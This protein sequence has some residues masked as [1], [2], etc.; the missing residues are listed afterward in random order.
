LFSLA[1]LL[2]TT[3]S[4]FASFELLLLPTTTGR[5]QRID[6]ETG[7]ALGSY[8]GGSGP[9]TFAATSSEP[10]VS[11]TGDNSGRSYMQDYSTGSLLP[12]SAYS[13]VTAFADYSARSSVVFLTGN[14]LRIAKRADLSLDL[15]VTGGL[16]PG[17]SWRSGTVVGD[18]YY[19][20]GVSSTNT[21][22]WQVINLLN[23]GSLGAG[24]YGTTVSTV[25][26]LVG[27]FSGST[28]YWTQN[29]SGTI[30]VMRASLLA[31]SFGTS[32]EQTTLSS[33]ASG[34][35]E[36]PTL[37]RGHSS[38]YAIGR[39]AATA[40]TLKVT[41]LDTTF[42]VYNTYDMAGMNPIARPLSG[43]VVAPE[44]MSMIALG[45][46]TVALMRRRKVQK[47]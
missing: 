33:F 34:P 30:K 7:V 5:V 6:P 17:V 14:T 23:G 41:Q 40:T 2:L 10:G 45:L 22:A 12:S 32:F 18:K 21:V 1:A 39:S 37:V 47:S 27:A 42:G 26:S 11:Y 4:A 25:G 35:S 31:S 46:G 36:I 38:F 20:L 15:S 28:A 44:P 43:I 29:E 9:L 8:V 3:S 24:T 19:L 16:T 13:P